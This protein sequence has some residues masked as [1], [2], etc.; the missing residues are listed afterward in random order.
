MI[1]SQPRRGCLAGPA[2]AGRGA[3][4]TSLP[5]V[6]ATASPPC[7]NGSA[8][9]RSK[10]CP[11]A[12]RPT[13]AARGLENSQPHETHLGETKETLC[14]GPA[15]PWRKGRGDRGGGRP[16]TLH[17]RP[18]THA[19]REVPV[20]CWRTPLPEPGTFSGVH[21]SVNRPVDPRTSLHDQSALWDPE[22]PLGS[23]RAL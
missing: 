23:K 9:Q 11:E 14:E 8:L 6:R 18:R 1:D 16:L 17:G 7:R 20:P 15:P 2:P 10:F 4:S 13:E 3:G 5:G 12:Q 21:V 19:F 22:L